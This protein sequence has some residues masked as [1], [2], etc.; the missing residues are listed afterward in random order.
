VV[1]APMTRA[2]NPDNI[3]NEQTAIYYAQ[4]AS[5]GLIVSEGTTISEEAQGSIMVPGIWSQEQVAGWLKVTQAVHTAGGKIF[6]QLWH[7]GRMSH[8]SIQPDGGQPVSAS[9][10]PVASSPM[11]T[12]FVY[13]KDGTPGR[14]D[15]TPPRALKIEEVRRV[16]GDFAN[17]A[18]NALAAG[19]DGVEVHGATGYLFE[20]FLNPHVNQRIDH[21]G[22]SI[23]GR[24]RFALEVIDAIAERIGANR[25]GMRLSPRSTI[26]DM[27]DYPESDQTNLYL[28]RELGSREIAYLH[29]HDIG[30][31]MSGGGDP[32]I[33]EDLLR[34]LKTA[35]G[36][37]F[38]LAGGMT[39]ARAED[40]IKRGVI[41]LTAIGQPYIANPD[42]VE[43][44]RH[45]IPLATPDR[46]T[47]YGGDAR[48]YTDYPVAQQ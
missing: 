23:E 45:D 16:V 34:K 28:A 29:L 31:L 12:A 26:F 7:V 10:T 25:V 46:D 42:L 41:D 40:L 37:A 17:A 30:P 15:P 4:R 8:S 1:M 3:A 39:K 44:F 27:P 36:G 47:Y 18:E 48:G 14:V 9:S 38:L 6:A 21:Y 19:F 22:G 32:I 5:A 33:P 20:Q 11:S 43:R 35:F 2:R 24:S 13:H